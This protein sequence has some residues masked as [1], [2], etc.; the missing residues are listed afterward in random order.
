MEQT[1]TFEFKAIIALIILLAALLGGIIPLI[2]HTK[3]RSLRVLFFS[4]HYSRGIFLGAGMLHILPNAQMRF[5]Q[6]FTEIPTY[7]VIFALCVGTIFLIQFIEQGLSSI[8]KS[9]NVEQ[10]SF[11]SYLLLFLLSIHSI[12]A[13]MA[14]GVEHGI[15]T[16]LI[17]MVAIL[18][19]KSA[20]AFALSMNLCMGKLKLKRVLSLLML[21]A[22]MTPFGIALGGMV[23]IYI[24]H[25]SIDR[26]E[27][28]FDAIAAG[29]FIYI[30]TFNYISLKQE[31]PKVMSCIVQVITF[32]LGI[33]TMG[34]I[35]NWV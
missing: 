22:L 12:F 6:S 28:I 16:A 27:G 35:A 26:L 2:M 5:T 18:I 24:H 34:I 13:G 19:H 4:E 17:M 29:T 20:T 32:G 8:I 23:D 33:L 21:F 1:L 7:P 11:L 3:Q 9:R 25:Y 31:Q 14:I 15:E 10:S 30:A